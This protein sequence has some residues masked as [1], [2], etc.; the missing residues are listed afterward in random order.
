MSNFTMLYPSQALVEVIDPLQNLREARTLGALRKIAAARIRKLLRAAKLAQFSNSDGEPDRWYWA[1]PLL[2]DRANANFR[3][4][5]DAWFTNPDPLKTSPDSVAAEEVEEDSGAKGEHFEFLRQCFE[6]PGLIGLGPM[7]ENLPE[8]LADLALGAPAVVTLRSLH[9][10]FPGESHALQMKRSF[11]IADEFCALFNKPE[12]IAAVRLSE[13]HVW[14]WRMV[15]DYCGSG[16]LQSVLDEYFHLLCEQ[17][18]NSNEVIS[19]LLD[20]IN[21]NASV[22]NADSLDS[23][24]AGKPRKFRCHYAVEFG[25]QR[26]ETDS[27]QKRAKNLRKVFNS[28]FR[29]FLLSTTSIG[30]EGLD[31]HSYCRRIVHWNIPGNPVDLE[32]RE[33]RINRYKSLVIRQQLGRKYRAALAAKNPDTVGDPWKTL[34]EIADHHERV[35]T[36]K[37]ELV[38][39]W[40][41]DA[42]PSGGEPVK[43]ERV[44]PLYPF[45]IDRSRLLHILK[46]LAIYRLAFGQPRQAELVDHLMDYNLTPDELRTVMDALMID[47][48]PMRYR[49][50]SF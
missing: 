42:D 2:L 41:I 38:P 18:V 16:C 24:Q 20:A 8:I 4:N 39:Y 31:F 32:Q 36:G 40:H 5:T 44:I 25:S 15:A 1:A 11:A 9:R 33:G 22:I 26:V 37:S 30:Q 14:Y 49:S 21:L 27:G 47:L 46:T 48:S 13:N 6:D 50:S 17:E 23:F 28:P 45:S 10:I 35:L 19:Q 34:F 12:S 29:P 7:P 3:G 43:I